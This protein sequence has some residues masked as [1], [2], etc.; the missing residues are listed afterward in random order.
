MKKII[1]LL[2]LSFV[3]N[4]N[5]TIQM[6]L[7]SNGVSTE[8]FTMVGESVTLS[9]DDLIRNVAQ[10]EQKELLK[11]Y[12]SIEHESEA[13]TYLEEVIVQ[14]VNSTGSIDTGVKVFPHLIFDDNRLNGSTSRPIGNNSGQSHQLQHKDDIVK[15]KKL[16]LDY[17]NQAMSSS[18][19]RIPVFTAPQNLVNI[20]LHTNSQ[21]L[22]Y[23]LHEGSTFHCIT[24]LHAL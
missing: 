19:M 17:C 21:N 4:A 16:A 1:F 9:G 13:A 22:T 23:T 6:V 2:V 18:Q 10:M 15:V 11:A 20:L 24:A 14:V 12:A 3:V 5:D 8:N 7:E